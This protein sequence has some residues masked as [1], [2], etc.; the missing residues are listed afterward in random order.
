MD[1][2]RGDYFRRM[3][4]EAS[5]PEE[6]LPENESMDNETL[7]ID[8]MDMDD[9]DAEPDDE[10][11][12]T[13]AIQATDISISG[14]G[15]DTSDIQNEYDPKEI[16]RLNALIA[17]ENSAI[18][19]YFQGSKE[20]NVDVLRRLYA[21]I[22]E[23]ERFHSEQLIFAKSQLTGEKY[24]PRD[25]D[26]KKEFE[27]LLA[28][29]MDEETAMTTAVD[30]VGLM[31]RDTMTI[32]DTVEECEMLT[33]NIDMIES[34]LYQEALLQSIITSPM[35]TD[36]A[37]R[38]YAISVLLE[39]YMDMG[40]SAE[41]ILEAVS[42][43][44]DKPAKDVKVIE[45]PLKTIG[46]W[47]M[48][49]IKMIKN[50]IHSL[51][52][53]ATKQRDKRNAKWDWIKRHG[54]IKSL[55]QKGVSFYFYEEDNNTAYFNFA[56][57]YQYNKMLNNMMIAIRNELN[58]NGGRLP[59]VPVINPSEF[60]KS[61]GNT[62]NPALQARPFSSIEDGLDQI[63]K[64]H[65]YPTKVL[66]N[67]KQLENS[68]CV[69]LFGYSFAKM[70]S[71]GIEQTD[72]TGK[73]ITVRQKESVNIYNQ[74]KLVLEDT[75][76][77]LANAKKYADIINQQQSNIKPEAFGKGVEA[78]KSVIKAYSMLVSAITADMKTCMKLNNDILVQVSQM[79][80]EDRANPEIVKLRK[81]TAKKMQQ[82]RA[83]QSKATTDE[84][85]QK[86]EED[87]AKL[88]QNFE[89]KKAE[90]M[91]KSK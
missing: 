65:I 66:I 86:W 73:K 57:A 68:L 34:Q 9:M 69:Q 51:A 48:N 83:A 71:A 6:E 59:E 54:G 22:G 81:E 23:E 19:E 87:A 32:E 85:R 36:L 43:I 20:T 46:H 39:S 67:N 82:I 7:S 3:F 70:D 29:G 78:M 13:V 28:M 84:A 1:T 50:A 52:I 41:V 58:Q 62:G 79:D 21:D 53:W 15:D 10:G 12:D 30:K 76:N 56:P 16:D 72:D 18:G 11:D 27:E 64:L 91:N 42:N 61:G 14:F 60:E 63:K 4:M 5:A 8:S 17:S 74:M 75:N 38:D 80:S 77:Y 55:F 35:V 2:T 49:I 88:Q 37:A 44:A 90:L 47:I 33:R 40:P 24:V 31:P 25:P 26:V 89:A 45:N